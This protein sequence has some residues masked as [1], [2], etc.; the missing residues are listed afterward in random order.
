[1]K[2][3]WAPMMFK[4]KSPKNGSIEIYE[5]D[6]SVKLVPASDADQ[7]NPR[8]H[9]VYAHLDGSGQVFYVGKGT[10]SRAWSKQRHPLW[11]R[12][13]DK[14]LNGEYQVKILRDNLSLEEVQAF[15]E[16]WIAKYSHTVLNWFNWGRKTDCEATDRRY[17]L[18]TANVSLIQQAKA[19]ERYDPEKA[20]SMYIDAIK[21]IKCYAFIKPEPGLV[22]QLLE[23]EAEEFGVHGEIRALD[24]L[25]ICLVKLGRPDEAIQ[26]I[27]D[28][29][30]LYRRDLQFAVA[31]RIKKR[32]QKALDRN[33]KQKSAESRTIF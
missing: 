14:H 18:R 12:Y 16:A 2:F 25:T 5:D 21:A 28:Y 26:H 4:I 20:V 30:S 3:E 13:V 6:T 29:F 31:D 23:E 8:G 33:R 32:V 17:S 15:E 11:T 22:G 19:I 27:D 10:G 1:M 9:Y 24:R 7:K